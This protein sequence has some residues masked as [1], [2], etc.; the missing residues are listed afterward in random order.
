MIG[1]DAVVTGEGKLESA[2]EA[3]AVDAHRDRLWKPGDAVEHVLAVG[4]QALG[5]GGRRERDELLDIGAG[6]EVFRLPGEERNGADVRIGGERREAG[7]ELVL[8][9]T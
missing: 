2:A 7:E 8:H 9:G 3:G 6:D 4:R 1:R 5:F